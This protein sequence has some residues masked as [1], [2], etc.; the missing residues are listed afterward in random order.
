MASACCPTNLP[1]VRHP[2]V[3]CA[4]LRMTRDKSTSVWKALINWTPASRAATG[5][6]LYDLLRTQVVYSV[7]A[8]QAEVGGWY[9]SEWT[10]QMPSPRTVA[11][12]NIG[13]NSRARKTFPWVSGRRRCYH[14]CLSKPDISYRFWLAEAILDLEG[15]RLGLSPSL[16][17]VNAE[18]VS[19]AMQFPCPSP[20]DVRLR[21]VNLG[22]KEMLELLIINPTDKSLPVQWERAPGR[23]M[24]WS[25]GDGTM[26]PIAESGLEVPPRGWIRGLSSQL[27][28]LNQA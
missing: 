2:P 24:D 4:S 9:H 25:F 27:K 20:A 18:A 23:S 5:K 11:S 14:L 10:D 8:R 1:T 21:L 6:C 19:P 26:R 12:S 17:G 28:K 13:R 3:F 7:I 15:N 16:L 22:N